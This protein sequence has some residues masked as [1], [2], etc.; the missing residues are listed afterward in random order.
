[1][2]LDVLYAGNI[3]RLSLSFTLALES[4]RRH[5]SILLLGV[6]NSSAARHL[7]KLSIRL[8]SCTGFNIDTMKGTVEQKHAYTPA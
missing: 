7:N 2:T 5:I 4:G 8:R 3:R 1:M 6:T